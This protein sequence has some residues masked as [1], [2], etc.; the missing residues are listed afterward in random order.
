MRKKRQYIATALALA[1]VCNSVPVGVFA[2]TQSGVSQ[3]KVLQNDSTDE[4]LE[5]GISDS[6]SYATEN[7]ESDI[8]ESEDSKESE[9]LEV[10]TGSSIDVQNK[11]PKSEVS[12][13]AE[14]QSWTVGDCTVT[15]SAD[16]KTFTVTG[17]GSSTFNPKGTY[18]VMESFPWYDSLG[19]VENVTLTGVSVLGDDALRDF[20]MCN[21]FHADQ[22]LTLGSW[23]LSSLGY[24]IGKAGTN[25][26]EINITKSNA[27]KNGINSSIFNH[28]TVNCSDS[29]L[30]SYGSYV[31]GLNVRGLK[32]IYANVFDLNLG[33]N[34]SLL[35][36]EGISDSYVRDYH[37]TVNTFNINCEGI[38]RFNYGT[39]YSIGTTSY[40]YS[41]VFTNM[42]IGQLNFN[43]KDIQSYRQVVRVGS[44]SYSTSSSVPSYLFANC[45]LRGGVSL[46]ESILSKCSSVSKLFYHA[47]LK[48]FNF[49]SLGFNSFI[50]DFVYACHIGDIN[51]DD[52][53]LV[54][55][56]FYDCNF[57]N[58]TATDFT[59]NAMASSKV[60][61][62]T[63]NGKIKSSALN[64]GTYTTIVLNGDIEKNCFTNSVTA[65]DVYI[66]G[67]IPDNWGTYGYITN[68][69]MASTIG[70][71]NKDLFLNSSH[72]GN[73]YL[74]GGVSSIMNINS[75]VSY[76]VKDSA[77]FE[78]SL[79]GYR[80]M[81]ILSM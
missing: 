78:T 80:F 50:K 63:V 52:Y 15:L 69:H 55:G 4:D 41:S 5:D 54:A 32:F 3:V 47:Y 76:Y 65:T 1:M 12:L 18:S 46:P 38:V 24:R 58:I 30:L 64:S 53:N 61:S 51:L 48:E 7:S 73:F 27:T 45:V 21:N 14:E 22:A 36:G 37:T 34:D 28:L 23:S 8:K 60:K 43:C 13:L 66:N 42:R 17:T 29:S 2:D 81:G 10:V 57:D 35:Q 19:V 79:S 59:T 31:T 11:D 68:M 9:K 40:S 77:S 71:G 33:L 20:E 39:E 26:V 67:N 62:L 25:E 16:S 70:E 72:I 6:E 49:R 75:G 44:N 56:S 74:D